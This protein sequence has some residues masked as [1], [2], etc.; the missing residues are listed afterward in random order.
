MR[1]DKLAAGRSA[2]PIMTGV[3]FD[4]G[5][6][7]NADLT[8]LLAA[9]VDGQT[10]TMTIPSCD[11]G[12]DIDIP[13]G[14]KNLVIEGR[15]SGTT[16]RARQAISGVG[17]INIG[18]T[19]NSPNDAYS[20]SMT[21]KTQLSTV[22]A[23][24]LTVTRTANEAIVAQRWYFLCDLD[25]VPQVGA[26]DILYR[27]EMVYVTSVAGNVATLREAVGRAYDT[28]VRLL[29]LQPN[30]SGGTGDRVCEN[31]VIRNL[32]VNGEYATDTYSDYG[33][34][35]VFCVNCRVE[36]VTV[37]KCRDAHIRFDHSID[38]DIR[39]C[40]TIGGASFADKYRG[41]DLYM[42]RRIRTLNFSASLVR[43]AYQLSG[44]QDCELIGGSV[45]S[46]YDKSIDL[47][48]R[49][50]LRNTI[51]NVTA[52]NDVVAGNPT[53][54]A[55]DDDNVF[56]NVHSQANLGVIGAGCRNIFRNCS[57]RKQLL[58]VVEG[59]EDYYPQDPLFED[60]VF[61]I[62]ALD[63]ARV[64]NLNIDQTP[65]GDSG[66]GNPSAR[67][68]T[69]Y[70]ARRCRFT[71]RR[72]GNMWSLLFEEIADDSDFEFE[73]CTF[74]V[75]GSQELLQVEAQPAGGHILALGFSGCTFRHYNSGQYAMHFDGSNTIVHL[76]KTNCRFFTAAMAPAWQNVTNSANVTQV[77]DSGNSIGTI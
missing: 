35:G 50:S 27:G 62:P 40:S 68:V 72:T 18:A 5:A 46:S 53:F 67:R 77:V 71:N 39:S 43:H 1:L 31:I 49:R 14:T 16:V 74:E 11:V 58:A 19:G 55:G 21:S 26:A 3:V 42:C 57:A 15:L 70:T 37:R 60:C 10:V 63:I 22:A 56:E 4:Y 25:E 17:V 38:C 2:A 34:W 30:G 75:Y 23:G 36:N 6:R 59:Y 48:G 7:I 12:V 69:G 73:D 32:T 54:V 33:V 28:N 65:D 45:T 29:H 9:Q 64:A 76:S 61:D 44:C 24:D 20:L 41:I 13:A 8:A 66:D 51:R 47:H 52:D